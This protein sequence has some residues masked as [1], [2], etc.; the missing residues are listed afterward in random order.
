MR[1]RRKPALIFMV[2][3]VVCQLLGEVKVAAE[4]KAAGKLLIPSAAGEKSYKG[5]LRITRAVI[6]IE[7]DEKI[8]KPFNLDEPGRKQLNIKASEIIKIEIDEKE[9]KIYLRV[10]NSFVQR[11]RNIFNLVTWFST[12][13]IFS[14][15]LYTEFWAII[16]A[17]ENPFNIGFLDREVLNSINSRVNP[18][19]TKH[20]FYS[21][22]E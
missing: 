22:R 13:S 6:R 9:K 15:D 5:V 12:Y 2:T 16:F 7:C 3:I 17:Y 18:V 4:I 10:E 19:Y 8:F 21:A 14:G 1:L 11:Y 20:Y